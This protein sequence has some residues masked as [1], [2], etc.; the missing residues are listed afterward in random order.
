[1]LVWSHSLW[2]RE[3]ISSESTHTETDKRKLNAHGQKHSGCLLTLGLHICVYLTECHVSTSP[4]LSPSVICELSTWKHSRA[5]PLHSPPLLD[6]SIC[7]CSAILMYS[8]ACT[9]EEQMS[10]TPRLWI[11]NTLSYVAA[12]GVSNQ[13][14]LF[15]KVKGLAITR[16]HT[17][18]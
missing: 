13:W 14:A 16:L 5:S 8:H 2:G 4:S 15:N 18:L 7:C 1:M 11:L 6:I 12:C 10:L 3:M 9:E 17:H